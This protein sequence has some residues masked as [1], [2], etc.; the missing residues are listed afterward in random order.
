MKSCIYKIIA[1]GDYYYI[2]STINVDTR[3]AIHINKLKSGKHHNKPMQN[4]FNRHPEGWKIVVIEEVLDV[5]DLFNVEQTYL[6]ENFNKPLC[7]NCSPVAGRPLAYKGMKKRPMSDAT[8]KKISDWRKGRSLVQTA[9]EKL[10]KLYKGKSWEEK[11][12]IEGAKKRRKDWKMRSINFLH[13]Q[14]EKTN[15]CLKQN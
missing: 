1:P 2:G 9:K 11:Y 15:K 5:D 7:M 8:K 4:R 12:G 3:F 14:K 10:S 13:E 6:N